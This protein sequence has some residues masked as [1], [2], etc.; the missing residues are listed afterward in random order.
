MDAR[1]SPDLQKLSLTT[2]CSLVS[3]LGPR[4]RFERGTIRV[5]IVDWDKF[6][7]LV[8]DVL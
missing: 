4:S 3:Y 8:T 7:F 6:Y 2:E 1:Q 5:F